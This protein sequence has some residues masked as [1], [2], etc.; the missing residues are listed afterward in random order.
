MREG[1]VG[2]GLVLATVKKQNYRMT[3]FTEVTMSASTHSW[4][5]FY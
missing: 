4:L 2:I 5:V 3:M 1:M